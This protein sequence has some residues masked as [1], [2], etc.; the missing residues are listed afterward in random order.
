MRV[1]GGV[2]LAGALVVGMSACSSSD[3]GGSG[4]DSKCGL[5]I[6]FFGA[7][8][9]D[10]AN[11]GIN[12]KDGAKL[13]VEQYNE[14]HAD[15][16]VEL[17]EKD[18]QGDEKQ[19]AGLAR[20]VVKDSKVVGVIGPAF[21]GETE[22]SGPIWEEAKL[23]IISPS[24][25]RTSLGDKGWK[26]FHRGLGNDASQGPA[27]AAY[28]KDVLKAEKVYV[29]DDQSAY[30]A[31]LADAVRGALGAAKVG[32]DKVDRN[33]TKDFNPVI[34][35]IKASGATAV[36]YGGYYQEA[37]LLVKQM[38]AAGVTATLVAADGVKDPAYIETAGK[39][40]AEGTILTCPCQPAS[41]AKGNFAESYKAKWGQE[42][43]TYSDIAFD[44]A[45]IFLKGIDEGNTT[46]EKMLNY[47]NGVTYEGVANT[48]KFT[49]KGELDPQYLKIWAY[50]VSGGEIV[51]DQEIKTQ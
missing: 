24:A 46:K 51:A 43:G 10:A 49:D 21:S 8:T 3:G 30:G 6:T 26:I 25:T 19:A 2:A 37:G 42:A 41:E 32:D 35:K 15:C 23:P 13:A 48:Y 7:L 39:E 4:S 44:I 34:T 1:I 17:V 22:A 36:F 45:G 29:I 11:L 20:E 28:I 50:K 18:S 47:V 12:I 40:Q 27:A 5:K 9:G 16:K 33:V 38:R 14:K 31:G